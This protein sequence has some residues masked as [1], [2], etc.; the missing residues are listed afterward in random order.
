MT[1]YPFEGRCIDVLSKEYPKRG[2]ETASAAAC[3]RRKARSLEASSI[4]CWCVSGRKRSV[5]A[6]SRRT[7]SADRPSSVARYGDAGQGEA[8]G[9]ADREGETESV[10]KTT[11]GGGASGRACCDGGGSG[12]PSTVL[13]SESRSQNK[14]SRRFPRGGNWVLAPTPAY[15]NFVQD[16]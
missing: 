2:P 8:G 15:P 12:P 5:C 16:L 11:T 14:K 9:E 1:G 7:E 13:A 6:I 4:D 10:M 3:S